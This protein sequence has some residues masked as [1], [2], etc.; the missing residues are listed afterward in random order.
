MSIINKVFPIWIKKPKED[1]LWLATGGT[2]LWG[3]VSSLS[4]VVLSFCCSLLAGTEIT[5]TN[6]RA[7]IIVILLTSC[8]WSFISV[9]YFMSYMVATMS[10][11][12]LIEAAK[13]NR[14]ASSREIPKPRINPYN[15]PWAEGSDD[16]TDKKAY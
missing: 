4:I 14:F 6:H 9:G 15:D 7:I 8:I 2:F 10:V 3:T 1:S 11:T 12:A 16:K 13:W 5:S